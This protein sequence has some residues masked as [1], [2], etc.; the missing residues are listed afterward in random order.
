M[1]PRVNVDACVEAKKIYDSQH[2]DYSIVIVISLGS[3]FYIHSHFFGISSAILSRDTGEG[4][5]SRKILC[6]KE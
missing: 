5:M 4:G 6:E 1:E 2:S 3:N